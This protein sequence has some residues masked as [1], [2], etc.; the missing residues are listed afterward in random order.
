MGH[1]RAL[2]NIED[3]DVQID[4]YRKIVKQNLSVRET[5]SLVKAH[6]DSLKPKPTKKAGKTFEI[7][8]QPKKSFANYFGAKVD[9]KSSSNGKGKI[10]IPFHSEEDF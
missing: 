6:Q 5:E 9:I 10:I 8:D 1:G 7:T 2:I 3:H 4:I